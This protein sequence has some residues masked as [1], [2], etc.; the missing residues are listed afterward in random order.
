MSAIPELS[1]SARVIG[2]TTL[3]DEAHASLPQAALSDVI[4]AVRRTLDEI[5]RNRIPSGASVWISALRTEISQAAH[6]YLRPIEML[7]HAPTV[8]A[9]KLGPSH[10]W[11]IDAHLD[12]IAARGIREHGTPLQ[13]A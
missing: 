7:M 4:L 9:Q 1:P 5:E 10:L 8:G 12:E 6:S 3:L 2:I 13:A 11:Q